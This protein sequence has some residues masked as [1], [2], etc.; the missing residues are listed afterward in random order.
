[1]RWLWVLAA[2]SLVAAQA[3]AGEDASSVCNRPQV[4]ERVETLLREAGRPMRFDSQVGEI[5]RGTDRVVHCAV[6]GQMLAYDTN[7][8]GMQPTDVSFVVQFTLEL[9]QNG[10]FLHID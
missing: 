7:Q 8:H 4:V 1:M 9:R 5:S 2:S 10:M 3:Q 6:H